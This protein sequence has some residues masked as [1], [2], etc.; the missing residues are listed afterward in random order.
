MRKTAEIEGWSEPQEAGP[1]PLALAIGERIR[2]V[3]PIPFSEYMAA[4]LYGMTDSSG[5]FHP[6]YYTSTNPMI[7]DNDLRQ[8]RDWVDFYT[9]PEVSPIFGFA[10]ARQI[11]EMR[12]ILG[13]NRFTILEVGAGSGAM[14]YDILNGLRRYDQDE[15]DRGTYRYIIVEKSRHLLAKQRERLQGK[16]VEIIEGDA[17]DLPDLE[18]EGL[19]I[20]NELLDDLPADIVHFIE[21]KSK[22]LMVGEG[23]I[24]SFEKIFDEPSAQV[25]EYLEKYKVG[26]FGDGTFPVN[27]NY[28]NF[29][30]GVDRMLQRGFVLTIDYKVKPEDNRT[31]RG[32]AA[33]SKNLWINRHSIAV[34]RDDDSMT[35][36]DPFEKAGV[37]RM[38]ITA[39][40][41]FETVARIGEEMGL[42]QVGQ[43]E[44]PKFL[45]NLGLDGM[46]RFFFGSSINTSGI[47]GDRKIITHR[48]NQLA[49]WKFTVLAQSKGLRN[50]Q[51]TG[52]AI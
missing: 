24:R 1:T 26:E 46:S 32:F 12:G 48:I 20:T 16:P 22:Q 23:G 43:I 38:N 47:I 11:K 18:I 36:G 19:I 5:I 34:V 52:L 6:G 7:G 49:S 3:G 15:Y 45:Y 37:G 10:I 13:T 41:D 30:R 31:V 29:F 8:S 51:L 21:G 25:K 14:A 27:F 39:D 33:R 35:D 42:A 40:V 4:A 2:A 9:S 44:Q 17:T 28:E 50:I